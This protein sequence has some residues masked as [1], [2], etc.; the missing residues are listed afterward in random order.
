MKKSIKT[1]LLSLALVGTLAGCDFGQNPASS[2]ASTAASSTAA[3]S[4]AGAMTPSPRLSNAFFFKLAIGFLD[5]SL[6]S[7]K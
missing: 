1:V 4:S 6:N 5:E 3:A 7:T 2:S